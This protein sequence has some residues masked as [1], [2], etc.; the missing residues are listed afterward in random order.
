MPQQSSNLDRLPS[1]VM[2]G[3]PL[4]GAP[5]SAQTAKLCPDTLAEVVALTPV[6]K[7]A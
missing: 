1:R 2:Y 3:V 6:C 4:V 5:L 7:L